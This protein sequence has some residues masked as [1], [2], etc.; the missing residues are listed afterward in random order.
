MRLRINEQEMIS[1]FEK[2]INSLNSSTKPEHI[3]TSDRMLL[4]T[5]KKWIPVAKRLRSK[6]NLDL[7]EG[8]AIVYRHQ[9][10]LIGNKLGLIG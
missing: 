10:I 4:L 7:I 9:K 2:V 1:D 3:V 8:F 6:E 5:N